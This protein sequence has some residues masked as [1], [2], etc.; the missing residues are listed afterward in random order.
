MAYTTDLASFDVHG[1]KVLAVDVKAKLGTTRQ[2]ATRLREN[3]IGHGTNPKADF[4][5]VALPDRLYLWRTTASRGCG[6]EPMWEVDA[7]PY[8]EPYTTRAGISGQA[9]KGMAFEMIVSQWIG[10]L[11]VGGGLPPGEDHTWL[12]ESG[13]LSAIRDGHV[14]YEVPA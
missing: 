5:L 3:M 9:V 13:L 4:F 1:Q 7:R 8:L 6:L 11:L 14:E 10:D 2:W 12:R